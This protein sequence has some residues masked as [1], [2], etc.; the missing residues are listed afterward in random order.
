[1]DGD[2]NKPIPHPTTTVK[3]CRGNIYVGPKGKKGIPF[4]IE[5]KIKLYKDSDNNKN[6]KL[7]KENKNDLKYLK[8]IIN[9]NFDDIKLYWEADPTT[10]DGIL[11]INS[12]RNKIAKKYNLKIKE[13]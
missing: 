7:L 11:L 10:K 8:E 13:I 1:M 4:E 2:N 6:R 5:P 9:D 3:L 12:I